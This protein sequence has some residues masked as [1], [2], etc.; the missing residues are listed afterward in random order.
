M[1]WLIEERE[2]H[3]SRKSL[4]EDNTMEATGEADYARGMRSRDK[5]D[6]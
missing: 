2:T 5:R 6:F 4:M 1:P 3:A